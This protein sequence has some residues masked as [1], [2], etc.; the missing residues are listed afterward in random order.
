MNSL[1]VV[2]PAYNEESNIARA[3][4]DVSGVLQQLKYDHEILV[5]NDGSR[6]R[7]G[8][9]VREV[10]VSI[11]ALKLVEHFP[12]RGYGGALKAGFATATKDLIAFTPADNQ[13]DFREIQR[14]LGKLAP[15]VVLVSG[16]RIHRQDN[17]IRKFNGFGWN[18][19][20]RILFGYLITDIDCGFK[21]FRR[22]VLR[23]IHVESNGAMIDTE[24]LA[25]LRVRGYKLAE[26]PVTH[27]PRTAGS[28]TGANIKVVLRAFRDL[29]KFRLRLWR[30]LREETASRRG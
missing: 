29:F 6:D 10:M 5:V 12:N 24:M 22:E 18:S 30:E 1:S 13:F 17:I 26:V 3:V 20:V 2:I 16:R 9:I 11:P 25:E 27:R 15:D 8:E 28:P 19:I 21:V 14:L 4:R 23:H 7:T